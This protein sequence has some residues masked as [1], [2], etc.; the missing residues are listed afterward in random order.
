MQ[1][2][3]PSWIPWDA[4]TIPLTSA[5][6]ADLPSQKGQ[7]SPLLIVSQALLFP[8]MNVFSSPIQNTMSPQRKPTSPLFTAARASYSLQL[9][10][11]C[12]FIS[13]PPA[14]TMGAQ[15]LY[16]SGSLLYLQHTR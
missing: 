7:N 9:Y 16:M 14:Y 8:G 12:R 3:A 15:T 1:G 5:A 13:L 11:H 4:F 2:V 6:K 10:S